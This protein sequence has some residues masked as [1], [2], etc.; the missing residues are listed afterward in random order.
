MFCD[1]KAIQSTGTET[2]VW[3]VDN[4]SR[5]RRVDVKIGEERDGRVEILKGLSGGEQVIVNPPETVAA[6]TLVKAT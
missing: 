3:T 1:A 5:A 6:G 4:E 2:F